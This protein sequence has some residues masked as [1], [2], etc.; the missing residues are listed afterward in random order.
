M[1]RLV[2]TLAFALVASVASAQAYTLGYFATTTGTSASSPL[3]GSTQV[4]LTAPHGLTQVGM[5]ILLDRTGANP[6]L[7]TVASIASPTSVMLTS[8][9][10]F[11]HVAPF[12]IDWATTGTPAGTI[13]IPTATCGAA[14]PVGPVVPVNP[15]TVAWNDDFC[16]L[17][18]TYSANQ[19]AFFNAIPVGNYWAAISNATGWSNAY[20]FGRALRPPTTFRIVR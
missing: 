6:E 10:L 2:L 1:K 11:P 17:P 14:P 7:M 15:S 5:Q 3:A 19:P 8:G 12:S 9:T 20:P 18:Q 13:V 4:T 16:A